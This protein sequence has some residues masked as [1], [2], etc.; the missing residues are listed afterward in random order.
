MHLRPSSSAHAPLMTRNYSHA[1][2]GTNCNAHGPNA[3]TLPRTG[4]PHP[5]RP[6]RPPLPPAPG[7]AAAP[8]R[9]ALR[10]QNPAP[11]RHRHLASTQRGCP[12]RAQCAQIATQGGHHQHR[13]PAS[14]THRVPASVPRWTLRRCSDPHNSCT[15]APALAHAP[16]GPMPPCTGG[17]PGAAPTTPTHA[18]THAPWLLHTQTSSCTHGTPHAHTYHLTHAPRR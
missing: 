14:C 17:S 3:H 7:P 11:S 5:P 6:P 13:P 15:P 4:P 12:L 9:P 18:H 1:A 16:T 2:W 10:T 8:L